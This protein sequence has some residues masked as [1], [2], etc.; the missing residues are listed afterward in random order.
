MTVLMAMDLE[1]A[2]VFSTLLGVSEGV[3]EVEVAV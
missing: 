3:V 2:A 1:E